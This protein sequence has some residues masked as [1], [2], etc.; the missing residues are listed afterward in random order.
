M[1]ILD[2]VVLFA[3][4]DPLD[5]F[6]RDGVAQLRKAGGGTQIGTSVLMEFD[7]V[8]K[9]KGL[10]AGDR[11]HEMA[12]LMNDYPNAA[13]SV[14][15]ISS[16]T[17]YLAALHEREFGLDYF[18]ALIAAEAAEQDGEVVSSDRAFDSV[19]NL[20]RVPLEG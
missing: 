20:K 3:A 7:I 17:L 14:H 13:S 10:S 18:D 4:A 6:H 15:K 19:P 16:S 1:P 11:M 9:S 2:T 12:L 5:K 8:L